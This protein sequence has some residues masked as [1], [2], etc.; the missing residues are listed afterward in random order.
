MSDCPRYVHALYCDDVRMEVG[1][2]V[3]FV[4]VYQSELCI[5]SDGPASLSKLCVVVT[6]QTPK[7]KPFNNL[8]LK[9]LKDGEVLQAMEVPP[10][11]LREVSEMAA[12]TPE[13]F[14]HTVG[15][16]LIMQPFLVEQSCVLRVVAESGGD[17]LVSPML[18]VKLIPQSQSTTPTQ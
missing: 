3:T 11:A 7:E 8:S 17:S 12:D 5:Q 14:Y 18:R 9:L 6:A 15:A 10:E 2:K 13:S 4:G 1:G 16:F